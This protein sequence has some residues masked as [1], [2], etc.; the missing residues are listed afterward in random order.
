M[1]QQ[2]ID[3]GSFPNDPQAD[4]IR[5]AFEKVQNNFTELYGNLSSIAGNVSAIV[6]GP[7]ILASGST[8][9]VTLAAVLNSV[10]VHSDTIQVSGLGGFV[11]PGG[12]INRDYTVNNSTNTLMLELNSTI[13]PEFANLSLT[14]NLT[15]DGYSLVADNANIV[16]GN[17]NITLS[18]GSFT[19]N[20]T[21]TSG[22]G[23]VSFVGTDS[24]VTGDPNF[25]YDRANALLTVLGG[26]ITTDTVTAGYLINAVN[27][28][29]SNV[30]NIGNTATVGR[31][32]STGNVTAS[33]GIFTG[34]LSV[35]GNVTTGS[36]ISGG[37]ITG[38][39]FTGNGFGLTDLNAT[40]ITAGTIP[41]PV[42]S[43]NYNISISG[44]SLTA[45]TVTL[46]SQPN[47]TSV[48][49]L[50]DLTVAG[51]TQTGNLESTGN[52]NGVNGRFVSAVIADNITSNTT[53]TGNT[54]TFSGLVT[55]ESLGSTTSITAEQITSNTSIQ[56]ATISATGNIS[57]G[58]LAITAKIESQELSLTGN[59]QL[60]NVTGD[61]FQIGNLVS[62][63]ALTSVELFS[64]QISVLGNTVT[65]N[66][67][68]NAGT[69]SS[70]SAIFAGAV[71][72]TNGIFSGNIASGNINNTGMI[73][74]DTLSVVDE[75]V[76]D[77]IT[78]AD[79]I[80]TVSLVGETVLADTI[81]SISLSVSD[82]AAAKI[83][84]FTGLIT[85]PPGA[86]GGEM[87]Y[88]SATGKFRIYNGVLAQWQSLN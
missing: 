54:G 44:S 74:T 67:Y 3:Y 18:S 57:A 5:I 62:T 47:I 72:A 83:V 2:N 43:G 87:Y 46:G 52:I 79:S 23:T 70:Q 48:G 77:R 75:I 31:L 64:N 8:G 30:A 29:V 41:T 45:E 73:S 76:S 56:A 65:G 49:T 4:A 32:V 66:L 37:N 26:N 61:N 14:G 88:N 12:V 19:G 9:S 21:S 69:V 38:L 55:V 80:T 53:L 27:L 1:A 36:I 40:A 34:N 16:L 25:T 68:A 85:D 15:I 81:T 82:T 78:N 6:A 10:T 13:S 84:R 35:A 51:N 24:M 71:T 50:V 20:I 42:L 58:N 86:T 33:D 39:L 59:A 22:V 11:P 28:N 60:S 7:G 63:G 17:G